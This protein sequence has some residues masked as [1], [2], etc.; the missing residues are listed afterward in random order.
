MCTEEG[1]IV[2]YSEKELSEREREKKDLGWP[3]QLASPTFE[4]SF[5]R[6]TFYAQVALDVFTR[7]VAER[8]WVHLKI[9]S[10]SPVYALKMDQAGAVSF[11]HRP[12]E[13]T[14]NIMIARAGRRLNLLGDNSFPLLQ[15]MWTG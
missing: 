8:S 13:I 14:H 11:T 9:R 6:Q 3:R 7:R 2:T 1:I 5:D 10:M 12:L 15:Q 4:P